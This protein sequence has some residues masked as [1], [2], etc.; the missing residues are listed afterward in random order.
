MVV[1]KKRKFG[2]MGRVV[3]MLQMI[4]IEKVIATVT[5]IMFFTP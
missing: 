2:R 4:F 1:A 5:Q 3:K